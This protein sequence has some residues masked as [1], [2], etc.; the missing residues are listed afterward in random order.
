MRKFPPFRTIDPP[1]TLP[2]HAH[3]APV[4]HERRRWLLRVMTTSVVGALVV[5][6]QHWL[7][8]ALALLVT[9]DFPWLSAALGMVVLSYFISSRVLTIVLG[10]FGHR[11]GTVRL[12]I[13]TVTAIVISQ[14]IPA[15]GVASYAFLV[16]SFKL[17]GCAQARRRCWQCSRPSAMSVQCC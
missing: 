5:Y 9:A 15:G 1:L 14:C 7:A 13:T 4:R 8:D 11:L 10:S 12:W 6:H 3:V 2:S 16:G 17:R